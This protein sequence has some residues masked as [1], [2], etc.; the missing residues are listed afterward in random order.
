MPRVR[1]V[2]ARFDTYLIIAVG[3]AFLVA[4]IVALIRGTPDFLPLLLVCGG[5]AAV[6]ISLIFALRRR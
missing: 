3:L 4:V 6:A 1:E 5:I 2:S